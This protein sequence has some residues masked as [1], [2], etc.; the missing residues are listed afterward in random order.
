M[1]KSSQINVN[2]LEVQRGLPGLLK[3]LWRYGLVLSKDPSLADDLVQAT[4]LRALEKSDQFQ[5]G[6][7]LD[8]WT[9]TIL[10]S[11]WKNELRSRSVR[12]GQGVI[13]AELALVSDGAAEIE[14]NIFA[15]QVLKEIELLPEA[16]RTAVFLV[17]G[18][19]LSY[20]EAA[21]VLE[22]PQG[23]IMSRL[24]T[25]RATLGALKEDNEPLLPAE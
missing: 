19:G 15:S 24:A 6:T 12:V 22:V 1:K 2:E 23:T 14:M 18:E 13:D 9:F 8:R 11:I 17:Y 10:S 7:S 25:A 4:C 5:T 20:K 16:Q 21:N 3:R